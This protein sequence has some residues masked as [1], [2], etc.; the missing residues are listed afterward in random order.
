MK[1]KSEMSYK[2]MPQQ[3]FHFTFHLPLFYFFMTR[4]PKSPCGQ[5][6]APP[7][8]RSRLECTDNQY[9][10]VVW[11]VQFICLQLKTM[12]T[13]TTYTPSI[14]SYRSLLSILAVIRDECLLIYN[15]SYVTLGNFIHFTYTQHNTPHTHFTF[16]HLARI[17]SFTEIHK[18]WFCS[19]FSRHFR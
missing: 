9:W 3:H 19:A 7:C 15:E 4:N 10:T 2:Y 13:T 14:P 6:F 8:M 18:N 12:Q 1:I 5:Q 16:Y 17:T 11:G